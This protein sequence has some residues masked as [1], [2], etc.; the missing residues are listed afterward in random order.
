M[1][2]AN[3][4]EKKMIKWKTLQKTPK[5]GKHILTMMRDGAIASGEVTSLNRDGSWA[6]KIDYDLCCEGYLNTPGT[7]PCTSDILFW[8]EMPPMPPMHDLQEQR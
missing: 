1:S 4:K 6:I 2:R 5:L 3:Q 7:E 8:A